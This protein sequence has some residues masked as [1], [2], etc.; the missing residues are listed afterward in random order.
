MGTGGGPGGGGVFGTGRAWQRAGRQ[1]QEQGVGGAGHPRI[2]LFYRPFSSTVSTG[3]GDITLSQGRLCLKPNLHDLMVQP[4]DDA[5]SQAFQS[6]PILRTSFPSLVATQCCI[7]GGCWKHHKQC[8][9]GAGLDPDPKAAMAKGFCPRGKP[10]EL[11]RAVGRRLK[12]LAG[13]DPSWRA[14]SS[15]SPSALV[16]PAS[17]TKTPCPSQQLMPWPA[18]C[19]ENNRSHVGQECHQKSRGT[20]VTPIL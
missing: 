8:L 6:V 9:F 2:M 5:Q 15:S 18:S 3:D 7:Q 10:G 1:G 16:S 13:R 14:F 19:L 11:L 17:S 4:H 12:E 20:E